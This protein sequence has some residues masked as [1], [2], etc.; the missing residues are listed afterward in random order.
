V[1]LSGGGGTI[2]VRCDAGNN[3]VV[4]RNANLVLVD[5]DAVN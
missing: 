1:S 2:D 5:V 4:A 3:T